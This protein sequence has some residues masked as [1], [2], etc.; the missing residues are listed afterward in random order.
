MFILN[1]GSSGPRQMSAGNSFSQQQIQEGLARVRAFATSQTRFAGAIY[2]HDQARLANQDFFLEALA[3]NNFSVPRV[4]QGDNAFVMGADPNAP[5]ARQFAVES[6]GWTPQQHT[7][8]NQMYDNTWGALW[9]QIAAQSS[10]GARQMGDLY[11]ELQMQEM[12]MRQMRQFNGG[13]PNYY[14]NGY[15]QYAGYDLRYGGN[16]RYSGDPRYGGGYNN[17]YG[18]ARY[19]PY[20]DGRY[21]PYTMGYF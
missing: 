7:Q 6:R 1:G 20:G 10:A 4:R 18:S 8:Y 12:V 13:M 17:P 21:N 5:A 15:D 2:S 19:N 9:N 11:R 16:P 14:G 3:P